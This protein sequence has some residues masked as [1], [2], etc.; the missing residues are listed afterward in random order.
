MIIFLNRD[1]F[2]WEKYICLSLWYIT[3]FIRPTAKN[4]LIISNLINKLQLHQFSSDLSVSVVLV[5]KNWCKRSLLIRLKM[6]RKI[7]LKAY[8]IPILHTD[9]FSTIQELKFDGILY[10]RFVLKLLSGIFLPKITVWVCLRK[11]SWDK[12][13]SL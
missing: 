12:W 9:I 7:G 2:D 3:W 13:L 8:N 1:H 4:F 11:K 5:P 6:S 10:F